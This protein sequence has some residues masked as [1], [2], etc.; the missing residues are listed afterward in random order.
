MIKLAVVYAIVAGIPAI[1]AL[2][3]F[4]YFNLKF[5][6]YILLPLGVVMVILIH[7]YRLRKQTQ[8]SK[9]N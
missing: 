8:T 7:E 4:H 6:G 9:P 1:I 2:Y 5:P 3:L